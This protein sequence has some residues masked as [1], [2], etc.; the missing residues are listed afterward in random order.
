LIRLDHY[1]RTRVGCYAAALDK[2][3]RGFAAADPSEMAELAGGALADGRLAIACLGHRFEVSHP[4][5]RIRFRGTDFEPNVS[6]AII[7]LNHLARAD[8]AAQTGRLVPYR[9]LPDGQVFY[10]AF[11][12]Y[13]LATL[14]AGF[15]GAPARLAD[16][17]RLLGGEP[18]VSRADCTVRVPFFPRLLLTIQVW[19]ADEELPGSAN[20]LFDAVAPHYV[21]TED[22]AAVGS[23]V[24]HLLVALNRGAHPRDLADLGVV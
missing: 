16:A 18:A 2:A 23:Y 17:A 7:T 14:L 19:G 11:T 13:A 1:Q 3:V 9:E 5:G 15:S 8:G 12:R 20:I 22:A 6:L 21:H 4:D 10:G 24:A